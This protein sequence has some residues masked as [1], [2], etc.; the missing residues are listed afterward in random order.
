MKYLINVSILVFAAICF[1][2]VEAENST[3][4]QLVGWKQELIA[5]VWEQNFL[6]A[7]GIGRSTPERS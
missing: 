7:Q 5:I 6:L 2:S 1:S 4:E 3:P